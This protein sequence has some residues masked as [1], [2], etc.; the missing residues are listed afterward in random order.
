MITRTASTL[1]VLAAALAA[2]VR[3]LRARLLAAVALG[4]GIV[5]ALVS[6]NI[7]VMFFNFS[8]GPVMWVMLGEMFPNQIRGSGLAVSGFSQWIANFGI[9]LTFPMMAAGLGLMAAYSFY[10]VCA[11]LSFAFVLFIVRETKGRELEEM[12]G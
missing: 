11:V 3:L 6:A 1:L 4:A 12:T 2:S 9:T 7:Y 10:A 8:W 5:L